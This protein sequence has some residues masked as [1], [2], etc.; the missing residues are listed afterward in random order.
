MHLGILDCDRV[1]PDLADCFGQYADMFQQALSPYN[2]QFSVYDGQSEVLPDVTSC[3]GWL[4]TGS[5]HA[6][7]DDIPWIH[8]LL[9]WIRQV[10]QQRRPLAGICFGHQIIAKA[11]GGDVKRAEVGWGVGTYKVERS[12]NP[13]WL[14]PKQCNLTLLVSHQDQ[15][16]HLPP[17][18]EL[19]YGNSFCPIYGFAVGR[20]VLTLQGHPEF[21][22]DYT[23]ALMERRQ[24]I[25]GELP[26]QAGIQSLDAE[27]DD[28]LA[29]RWL[30][31]FLRQSHSG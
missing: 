26:Y 11:L 6:A 19:L 28:A 21:S 12:D 18:A 16:T 4:I 15:V 7:Y 20:H 2:F 3:D 13:H 10:E 25:I 29:L 22:R 23:R 30:A 1:D 8:R 9:P 17:T 24:A 27:L 14:L 31:D 5:R